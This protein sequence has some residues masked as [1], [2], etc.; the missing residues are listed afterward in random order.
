[1]KHTSQFI[2]LV[3]CVGV[4]R[5]KSIGLIRNISLC[6]GY[7]LD[8]KL[9]AFKLFINHYTFRIQLSLKDLLEKKMQV[10]SLSFI[11]TFSI[12]LIMRVV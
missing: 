8:K 7:Q 11:Q 3:V 9:V 4:A 12:E 10:S 6:K 2:V 5:L 1:M